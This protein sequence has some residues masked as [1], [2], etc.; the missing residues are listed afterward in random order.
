MTKMNSNRCSDGRKRAFAALVLLAAVAAVAATAMAPAVAISPQT[1][2]VSEEVEVGSQIT[3]SVTLGDLYQNP[4]MEQWTLVG[5]TGLTQVTWSVGYFD[6][7]GTQVGEESQDGQQ[8]AS[9]QQITQSQ[10]IYEIQVSATG[11]VPEVAN[12][13]Y[14]PAQE[15]V[16]F[17][18]NQTRT[19]GTSNHVGEWTSHHYTT[20]SGG[21]PGSQ[22]ARNA[23]E[24]AQ[25][26]ITQ[27]EG[28]GANVAEE[29]DIVGNAISAYENGNFGNAVDLA[30]N[31]EQ[32]AN[33]AA[34][35]AQRSQTIL[36]VVGGILL[37]AVL[38]G[39][40][41]WY[42]SQQESYDKLA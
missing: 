34:G 32:N 25:A 36:Y 33:E 19:G 38:V 18:L 27:A 39:G 7:S 21:A 15:F 17:S 16:V 37:V 11:T 20:G 42:Q 40:V 35:G 23:I 30:N 2:N 13:T 14:D 28:A 26:A 29:R 9:Q 5:R 3:A 4:Q 31:A 41:L 6:A 10:N 24:Q 22:E 8:F 1:A 12:Y